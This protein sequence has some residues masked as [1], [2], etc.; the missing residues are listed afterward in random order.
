MIE[1]RFAR[2]C[3]W[4]LLALLA[5]DASRAAETV[6]YGPAPAWVRPAA[7][8][9]E[10]TGSSDAAIRLLMQDTQL[11]FSKQGEE[12]YTRARARIQTPQGLAAIGTVLLPWKPSSDTLTVHALHILR[13]DQV[14]DVLGAGQRFTVLRRENNVEY[15]ALDGVLTATIQ[16]AGLQVGDVLDLAYTRKRSELSVGGTVEDVVGGWQEL[17]VAHVRVR[18]QWPTSLAIRWKATEALG[19]VNETHAGPTTELSLA[20]DNIEPLAQP[21]GAPARFQVL[22][23]IEF[24]GFSSWSDVAARS[25][26]LYVRAATIAA[27]SPLRAEIARIKQQSN[28]PIGRAERALVLVQD[29][30][31][32]VYLG[33]NDGA[34]V[35]AAADV[36]WS[37]RFGDCKAKTALLLALLKEL[38]VH[39]EPVAVN[40]VL[41]DGLDS[42]LPTIGAFNH[43]L[44]R[45]HIGAQAY[46]LDGSRGG[47]RRLAALTIPNYRWGL[48]LV[49]P[50]SELVQIEAQPLIEP[51]V[52]TS[53]RIDATS[54]IHGPAPFHAE[55]LFGGDAG[56]ALRL[57]LAN[58]TASDLDRRLRAFWTN[59][60]GFVEPTSVAAAFDEQTGYEKLTADGVARMVWTSDRY[61]A[62]GL[63]VGYR[64]D[65]KRQAGINH[66]APFAV[67]FPVYARVKESVLLPYGG[68]QFEL[69]GHDVDR[70]IAGVEYHRHAQLEHGVFEAEATIRSVATE[71]PY[72][73]AEAAQTTLREMANDAVYIRAPKSYRAT[74]KDAAAALATTPDSA[75][76]FVTRGNMLLDNHDY[77]RAAADFDKAIAMDAK[78]DMAWADRGITHVWLREPD[79]A[80]HDFARALSINPRN[81]VVFR[82][83]GLMAL[84]AKH[85]E[86]AI[87]DF[88]T[89]L[90]L[91]PDSRFALEKRADA[92]LASGADGKALADYT[93]V[94]RLQP[95]AIDVYGTKAEI[96]ARRGKAKDAG[97]LADALLA[98]NPG[99]GSAYATAGPMYRLAGRQADAD[100]AFKRANAM[101]RTPPP[102]A[103]ADGYSITLVEANP[104]A[105]TP[106]VAG[107]TVEVKLTVNYSI[108]NAVRGDIIL[109]FQDD[110]NRHLEAGKRQVSR[111]VNGPSG[112]VSLSGKVK[113]PIDAEQ[114]RLFVP[115]VPDGMR[116]T[117][118]ELDIRYPI[119][120]AEAA[121]GSPPAVPPPP[122]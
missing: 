60:Y 119:T 64:A 81:V 111:T 116:A 42:R 106:L 70:T 26:P 79:L 113:V 117:Q 120:K 85:Y 45:A 3:A 103:P 93:M 94:L 15:A 51:L 36:T 30:V 105:G 27:K 66:D 91:E 5:V 46:W 83:R 110:K 38:D 41:G 92:Y 98:A 39:A 44:V 68:A 118:G 48:P 55:M 90:D 87:A 59:A 71:F 18:A 67:R 4:L 109:V 72:A 49:A 1:G 100:A 88:T 86:E 80:R 10:P 37:R 50:V 40:T 97:A 114:V 115:L 22:R 108:S 65:F 58:L 11:A 8:P 2:N 56:T 35:P 6:A 12:L 112:T 23:Q 52:S 121:D 16:P 77:A 43:V 20:L 89:A 96:L 75:S 107:S 33:M 32:Y 101:E 29:Q 57:Q 84:I 13:G 95:G 78:D 31:R 82:G 19:T 76:A 21:A 47:D 63:T 34:L 53:I 7:M 28:D 54:G 104:P 14:I 61:E 17:P 99:N 69:G 122:K 24:S 73:E 102:V 9:T 74:G 62:N 25:A